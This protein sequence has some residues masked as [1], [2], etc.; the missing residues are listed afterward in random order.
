MTGFLDRAYDVSTT[1][2]TRALYDGWAESYDA[3]VAENGYATPARCAEALARHAPL[4]EP[5]LD[6]GCGTGL[7]GIA[8]RARGFGAVDGA[9][10]SPEML[11]R[12]EATGAYRSLRVSDPDDPFEPG[13]YRIVTAVGVIGAGAAPVT[14]FDA[15][16]EALPQGGLLCLSLND[17]ALAVPEFPGRIEA[18]R[19]HVLFEEYGPHL[20]GIDLRSR[21]YVLRK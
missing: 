14:V 4:V 20:P 15:A 13:A 8:L 9:D 1:E 19:S 17:H 6:I 12:A 18:R 5:V 10:P 16:W 3:E 21:V 7:S 2:E 11:A